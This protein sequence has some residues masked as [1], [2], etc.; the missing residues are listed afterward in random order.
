MTLR[1]RITRL[2][3]RIPA[4]SATGARERLGAYIDAIAAR[5]GVNGQASPK[6]TLA[7]VQ[8]VLAAILQRSKP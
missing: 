5:F 7:D 2:E 8:N 6:S 4:Q 3:T 1:G